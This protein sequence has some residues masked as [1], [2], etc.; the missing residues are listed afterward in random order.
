M[1][2]YQS[3]LE[4]D[5]SDET[6]DPSEKVA[7]SVPSW[8]PQQPHS[9]RS[10]S[11]SRQTS[12][13]AREIAAENS[14]MDSRLGAWWGELSQ[15]QWIGSGFPISLLDNS[16]EKSVV[17]SSGQSKRHPKKIHRKSKQAQLRDADVEGGFLQDAVARNIE[18]LSRIRVEAHR[19]S[20]HVSALSDETAPPPVLPQIN[21]EDDFKAE[22]LLAR[23]KLRK[24]G[25]DQVSES[26]AGQQLRYFVGAMLGQAGF[27]GICRRVVNDSRLLWLLTF[28]IIHRM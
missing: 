17:T 22:E 8:Y 19:L 28:F 12:P 15:P 2:A 3:L 11:R 26:V 7:A 24:G 6:V 16:K 10:G 9:S 14:C 25:S 4:T 27:E 21:L 5:L 18:N 13:N 20:L 23:R 1:E